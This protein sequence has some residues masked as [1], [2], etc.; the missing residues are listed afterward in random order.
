M[1]VQS[2]RKMKKQNIKNNNQLIMAKFFYE[3]NFCISI[4]KGVE[5]HL[6]GVGSESYLVHTL[7][8][9]CT[10]YTWI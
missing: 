3:I 10:R 8:L 2:K 1:V 9:W 5:V 4:L 7:Q 6:C